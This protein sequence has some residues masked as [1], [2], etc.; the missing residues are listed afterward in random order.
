MYP[1]AQLDIEDSDG[2]GGRVNVE[3]ASDHYHAASIVAKVEMASRK[4]TSVAT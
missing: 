3:I 2:M 4:G 1:D